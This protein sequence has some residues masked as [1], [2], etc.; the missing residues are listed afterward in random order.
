MSDIVVSISLCGKGMS[1][2]SAA[3]ING[4]NPVVLADVSTETAA[5][6]SEVGSDGSVAL[7]TVMMAS[8]MSP[9]VVVVDQH[10]LVVSVIDS[11]GKVTESPDAVEPVGSMSE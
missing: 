7:S 1:V 9:P 4:D 6:S 2:V 11:G 5:G 3:A 8:R 10:S